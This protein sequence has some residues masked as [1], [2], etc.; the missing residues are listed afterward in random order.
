MPSAPRQSSAQRR[1][2]H[3]HLFKST[4]STT[5]RSAGKGCVRR[6]SAPSAGAHF[7]LDSTTSSSA[8]EHTTVPA[9]PHAR[10][11]TKG[12]RIEYKAACAR[13]LTA[14]GSE[15]HTTRLNVARKAA[16]P[17]AAA[18]PA[19]DAD[20]DA[21]ADATAAPA[22]K[23]PT[24]MPSKMAL[25]T[26][27]SKPSDPKYELGSRSIHSP[28]TSGFNSKRSFKATCERWGRGEKT[29]G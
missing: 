10:V 13:W 11:A 9:R 3:T 17:C 28:R 12:T 5:A 27:P 20:S 16:S 23:Q 1:V 2:A 6:R 22:A 24:P 19:A 29:R 7:S 18:A 25:P 14:A 15:Q 4:A 8:K 21:D 26:T